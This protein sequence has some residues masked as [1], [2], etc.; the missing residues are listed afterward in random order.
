M[1]R[2]IMQKLVLRACMALVLATAAVV[3]GFAQESGDP[4]PQKKPER[5]VDLYLS[6]HAMAFL[7]RDKDLT[8]GGVGIQGTDIRGTFGA[9]MKFEAYPWFTNKILG[10]EVEAFGLGGSVRAPRVT[11]GAGTTQAQG[12]LIAVNTMYNFML[13]YRGETLQ[14]YVGVG[15][16]SSMGFLYGYVDSG[17]RHGLEREFGQSGLRLSVPGR[18]EDLCDEA[19]VS[20]RRVQIFRD[21]VRLGRR[22]G[23]RFQGEARFADASYFRGRGMV[24]LTAATASA[25]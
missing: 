2:P 15:A 12:S 8:V 11:S 13:R 1:T 5:K 17:R 25:L 14:P 4:P 19:T 20:V 9:G 18:P 6:G 3:S 22:R 23:R 7:P 21:Q 16:G 10:G 24:V